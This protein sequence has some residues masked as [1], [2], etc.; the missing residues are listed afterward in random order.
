MPGGCGGPPVIPASDGGA[1][2]LEECAKRLAPSASARFDWEPHVS[3]NMKE[4]P[5]RKSSDINLG[6][7]MHECTQKIGDNILYRLLH[8]LICLER[9]LDLSSAAYRVYFALALTARRSSTC[10]KE[11]TR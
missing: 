10:V 8:S 9:M 11:Y 6:L 5:L 4:E 3:A 7:L 1:S 2:S